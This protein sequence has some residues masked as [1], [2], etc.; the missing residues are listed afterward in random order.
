MKI[1]NNPEELINY[2]IGWQIN[3]ETSSTIRCAKVKAITE[4]G[5]FV[6]K[7]ST[8]PKKWINLPNYTMLRFE[9]DL[10]PHRLYKQFKPECGE[11]IKVNEEIFQ[12]N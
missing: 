5:F 12:K 7:T 2:F 9:K 11:P 6:C 1:I 4:K 10:N 3:G 8:L